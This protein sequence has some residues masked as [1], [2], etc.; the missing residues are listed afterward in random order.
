[1][2]VETNKKDVYLVVYTSVNSPRKF[3]S[4]GSYDEMVNDMAVRFAK[5][6]F[7]EAMVAKLIDDEQLAKLS[8]AVSEKTG[9]ATKNN[10]ISDKQQADVK[11]EP[12]IKKAKKPR[13]KA[14][15]TY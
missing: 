2:T 15:R 4:Y 13:K 5:D 3:V 8:Q 7:A 9:F 12:V 10:Y 1:M 6:V 14:F 11:N